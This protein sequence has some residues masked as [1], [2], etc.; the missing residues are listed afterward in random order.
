MHARPA[1][2]AGMHRRPSAWPSWPRRSVAQTRRHV[3]RARSG[4]VARVIDWPLL[5]FWVGYLM[6]F[7]ATVWFFLH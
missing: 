6:F 5:G 7:V 3:H 1:N 4:N 2:P